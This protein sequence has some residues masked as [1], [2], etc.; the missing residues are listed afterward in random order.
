M[1]PFATRQ[2]KA[3]DGRNRQ[4][5]MGQQRCSQLP[6]AE[7]RSVSY[8]MIRRTSVNVSALYV[9]LGGAALNFR[10]FRAG[11][12]QSTSPAKN[13]AGTQILAAV[14]AGR[15]GFVNGHSICETRGQ[16]QPFVRTFHAGEKDA[17]RSKRY[18]CNPRI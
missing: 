11:S 18:G 9:G 12:G 3:R 17:I 5:A 4:A 13:P 15:A 7:M 14:A 1:L 10:I 16:A 2:A 6:G 8:R